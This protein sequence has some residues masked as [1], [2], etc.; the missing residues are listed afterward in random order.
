MDFSTISPWIPTIA[1]AIITGWVSYV[2]IKRTTSAQLEQTEHDAEDKVVRHWQDL[3]KTHIERTEKMSSRLD[4]LEEQNQRHEA[5]IRRVTSIVD[6]SIK[7]NRAWWDW[8]D[9]GALP[10][11]PARPKNLVAVVEA[12]TSFVE[13]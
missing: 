8:Y 7:H 5:E 12:L 13:E 4:A 6:L 3:A 2:N 10:P 9:S 1:A 11:P